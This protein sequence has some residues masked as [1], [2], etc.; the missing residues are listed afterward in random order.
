M[1]F[2]VFGWGK[3][4]AGELGEN[5]EREYGPVIR[6][7]PAFK[8]ISV[9]Q[10]A[11]GESHILALNDSG[12]LFSCGGNVCGQLGETSLRYDYY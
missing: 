12:V 9:Q 1:C 8:N 11:C 5:K 10:I 7:L 6:E 4:T 2:K 3:N